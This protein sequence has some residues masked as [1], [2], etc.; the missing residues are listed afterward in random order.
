MTAFM[1]AMMSGMLI[2]VVPAFFIC[3]AIAVMAYRKRNQ[4][5]DAGGST[6]TDG[7]PGSDPEP[8]PA[9]RSP[10]SRRGTVVGV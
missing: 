6:S 1:H 4:C 3:T 5:A 9:P 7:G 2:L 8:R 10:S